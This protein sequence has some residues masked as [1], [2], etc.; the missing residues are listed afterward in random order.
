MTCSSSGKQF[1]SI[2]SWQKQYILW[3]TLFYIISPKVGSSNVKETYIKQNTTWYCSTETHIVQ[4]WMW[5]ERNF[6]SKRAVFACEMH[7]TPLFG[8]YR[9]YTFARWPWFV[10]AA[11]SSS[12]QWRSFLFSPKPNTTCMKSV[13]WH[14]QQNSFYSKELPAK[15]PLFRPCVCNTSCN[16]NE[17]VCSDTTLL[18]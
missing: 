8:S 15:Q 7:T 1:A 4:F 17:Q 16:N 12:V 14:T 9:N 6:S 13:T 3:E 18:A 5:M 11:K 2:H 10:A